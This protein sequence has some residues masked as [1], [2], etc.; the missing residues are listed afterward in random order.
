MVALAVA[1]R[2]VSVMVCPSSTLKS[3][4]AHL[5]THFHKSY[6]VLNGEYSI[7]TADRGANALIKIWGA[8]RSSPN[9]QGRV[10]SGFGKG[11]SNC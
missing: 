4:H 8:R 3:A 10:S 5:F 1:D 2:R 7:A 6:R 9:H 11:R